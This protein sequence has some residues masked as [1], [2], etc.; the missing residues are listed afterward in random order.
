[1]AATVVVGSTTALDVV[2]D[3]AADPSVRWRSAAPQI[4]AVSS[5]GLVTGI[6]PGVSLVSA[7]W[8]QDTTRQAHAQVTVTAREEDLLAIEPSRVQLLVGQAARLRATR[9]GSAVA[10]EWRSSKPEVAE[11][12]ASGEVRGVADGEAA[13]VALLAEDSTSRAAALVLVGGGDPDTLPV[14]GLG[15]VTERYTGEVA[16]LGDWAY[17]STWGNRGTP[18]NA[19]KVWNVASSV[20]GLVD[21]LIVAGATTT[22]DVRISDDGGLLVVAVEPNPNGAIVIYDRGDPGRPRQLSRYASENTGQGVHT[23]KLGRVAGRHYAFLSIDPGASSPAKLVIADITDPRRPFEVWSEVMGDPFMHDVFVRDGILFAALWNDGLRIF[24]IG[25]GGQG[26][27]P[28]APVLMGQMTTLSG[29]VHNI[30]WFHDPANGSRRYVFL[31]EEAPAT[32]LSNSAGDI[33]VIDVRDLANPVQVAQFGVPDAGAHNFWM[34]EASGILY[35]AFYNG[36]VRALDVRGELGDCT[37]S[38]RNEHG[39]CDLRRTG[40]ERAVGLAEGAYIWGVVFDGGSLY[41]SDM[42][43]GLFK[44][45]ASAL[46][47]GDWLRRTP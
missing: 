43:Q 41:A 3:N 39:F 38:Y 32:I 33:H 22:G 5:T 29:S 36:G 40:R 21:S 19:I 18:G 14:L 15:S 17:T 42:T 34:D 2:V 9:A 10:V 7:I 26:G 46:S 47:R 20:P 4:A 23:V 12:D 31:G 37:A 1:M 25:G 45:D 24:D 30:W 44:L 35:Y 8:L 16:A 13:I 6:S 27:S 11:V 28:S